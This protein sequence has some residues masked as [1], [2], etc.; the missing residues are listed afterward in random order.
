MNNRFFSSTSPS[1]F[2][3]LSTHNSRLTNANIHGD[4]YVYSYLDEMF[5]SIGG[6]SY[7][8]DT[9]A[10]YFTNNINRQNTNNTRYNINNLNNTRTNIN[11][12]RSNVNNTRS[13]MNNMRSSMNNM[14]N[15]NNI[16]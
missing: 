14:N 3:S 4:E 1:R 5:P 15:M 8:F 12:T 7:L 13:N 16:V 2:E 9:F 6:I 10:N 11:N